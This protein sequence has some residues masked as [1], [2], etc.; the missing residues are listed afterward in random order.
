V[1]TVVAATALAG[2][3]LLAGSAAAQHT[4]FPP[5]TAGKGTEPTAGSGVGAGVTFAPRFALATY[6]GIGGHYVL[7]LTPKPLSCGHTYDA[8]PPYLT[9]T[10]VT[11]SSPLLVGAPSLQTNGDNFVQV[12]F[13]VAPIHYYTVQPGVKLVFTRIDATKNH[14]WHG[15]LTVPT[16]HFEGKTFAFSGMFAARWC[17]KD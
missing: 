1:R 13:Y 16:T 9:V 12:D 10:V 7:Y 6:D 4:P 15:K 17:G 14:L 2:A 11:K 5:K 8:K 3:L